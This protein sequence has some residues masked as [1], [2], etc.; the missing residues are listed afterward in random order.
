[1]Q[2]TEE[3][4]YLSIFEVTPPILLGTPDQV[5]EQAGKVNAIRAKCIARFLVSP[6]R[7][8]ELADT[9]KNALEK[10]RSLILQR[11][12]APT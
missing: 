7:M 12:V 10:F 11:Q 2:V 4:C 3:G 6:E 1:M 8:A 5:R 9:V